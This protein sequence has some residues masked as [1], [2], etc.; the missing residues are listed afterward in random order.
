MIQELI[1]N[2]RQWGVDKGITGP[3]GKGTLMA[4]L[5]K[6]QEELNEARDA[7]AVYTYLEEHDTGD[8]EVCAKL[9]DGIGDT[10]VTLI[11]LAQLAGTSVEYCLECAFGEIKN[12][13]GIMKDGQFIK[14]T[15]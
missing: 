7:A 12:R 10:M 6:S 2:V 5:D 9:I 4:Q 3:D 13:T 1:N 11:L 14:D 15:E 8:D